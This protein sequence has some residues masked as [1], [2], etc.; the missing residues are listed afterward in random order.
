MKIIT[1]T[2]KSTLKSRWAHSNV[3]WQNQPLKYP[4]RVEIWAL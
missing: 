1:R 4:V 3:A 2:Q